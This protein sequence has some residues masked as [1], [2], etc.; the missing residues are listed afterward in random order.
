MQ[1]SY[2]LDRVVIEP[3]PWP[4]NPARP[5]DDTNRGVNLFEVV[6]PKTGEVLYSRGFSTIFA[7]WRTTEEAQQLSR[8]FQESLRF[9]MPDRPVRV[10]VLTRDERNAF[11]VVWSVDV[12]PA[13]PSMERNVAPARAAADRHPQQ[14][15]VGKES[16]SADSRRRLYAQLKPASSRPTRGG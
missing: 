7:E 10:R 14:R 16:R 2:A 6:D 5:L 15:T 1:E 8:G 3:L 11:S 12:D 4:G 9:P 13:A